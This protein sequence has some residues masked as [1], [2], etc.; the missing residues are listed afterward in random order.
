MGILFHSTVTPM[1]DVSNPLLKSRNATITS[2]STIKRENKVFTR[3]NGPLQVTH[4]C[5]HINEIIGL[6]S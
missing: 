3:E 4:C 1:E 6:S 2:K 5:F